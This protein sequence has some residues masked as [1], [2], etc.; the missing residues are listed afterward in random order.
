MSFELKILRI[1]KGLPMPKYQTKESVGFDILSRENLEIKKGEIKLIPS[2]LIIQ[3]PE[4]YALFLTL[5][6]SVPK[7]KG[8]IM[9]HGVGVIDRDYCGE[10]DEIKIQVQ[11]IS[12][13]ICN[14]K[15]GERIAQG[16]LLK[17]PKFE[18]MEIDSLDKKNSR[19]GFGSTG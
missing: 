6:S 15:K 4:N 11:N 5:R 18:I 9:P 14:I 16:V 13:N 7:K 19:G 8:L 2:N 17:S 10:K 12:E 1:D 3:V